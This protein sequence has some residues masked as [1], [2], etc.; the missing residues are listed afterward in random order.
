M[1]STFY[2]ARESP[3]PKGLRSDEEARRAAATASRVELWFYTYEPPRLK[4]YLGGESVLT[5]DA[6]G[7]RDPET[8]EV[9]ADFLVQFNGIESKF[10]LVAYPNIVTVEDDP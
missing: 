7:H 10:R 3:L 4:I 5:R 6:D 1:E 9:D 2:L 8:G